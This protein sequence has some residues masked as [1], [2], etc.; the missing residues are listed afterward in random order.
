MAERDLRRQPERL[1]AGPQQH[2]GGLQRP[3]HGDA[4]RVGHATQDPRT[5]PFEA[6]AP[7][8]YES[9]LLTPVTVGDAVQAV[10]GLYDLSPYRFDGQDELLMQ[11]VAEQIAKDRVTKISSGLLAMKILWFNVEKT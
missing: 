11:A 6:D 9:V 7:V 8:R 2:A 4:V 3:E 10:I 5:A 1:P